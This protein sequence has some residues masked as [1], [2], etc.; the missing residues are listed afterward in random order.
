MAS[1]IIKYHYSKFYCYW[2]FL[3]FITIM[4]TIII[5]VAIII[6][7][8]YYCFWYFTYCYRVHMNQIVI[9]I[10]LFLVSL[11]DYHFYYYHHC[12]CYFYHIIVVIGPFN[13]YSFLYAPMIRFC[14]H[15]ERYD[16][17]IYRNP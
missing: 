14:E 2:R 11:I 4:A 16:G 12:N 6:V 17:L 13:P 8:G 5:V 15:L 1:F 9:I 7:D 10:N 3:G